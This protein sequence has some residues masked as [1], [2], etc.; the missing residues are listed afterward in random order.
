MKKPKALILKHC[1]VT[2]NYGTKDEFSFDAMDFQIGVSKK[3]SFLKK[4]I[5]FLKGKVWTTGKT[6]KVDKRY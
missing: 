6:L 5:N 3:E 1:K 2:V 4:F